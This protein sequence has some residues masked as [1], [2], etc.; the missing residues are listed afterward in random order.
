MENKQ[1]KIRT[2]FAPSPT[3]E[4]HLGGARTALFAYLFARQNKGK[5][6]LRIEDTDLDRLVKGA[7]KRIIESLNW[8]GIKFDSQPIYQSKRLKIYQKFAKKLVAENKAYWCH[9]SPEKLAQMRQEQ[10]Q[11]KIAPKYDGCCRDKN[12]KEQ[13]GAVVRLKMPAVGEITVNDLIRGEVI[14]KNELLDDPVLLKS[15]NYPT[16]HLANVID[17]YQTKI[18]HVIRSEEWLSSTPKH[19]VLYQA[20]GWPAPQFAHLPMILGSD[21]AKLSKR[22]GA[23]AVLD[24][25]KQGYLPE[26]LINFIA[27]L[28][29]NPGTEKEIFSLEELIK[30]FSLERVNESAA[31]FNLEKLNW[32]NGYYL[33][34]MQIDELTKKCLPYLED[35]G[36]LKKFPISNFQFLNNF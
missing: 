18:S 2:R 27:F 25:K 24:Y 7:D 10:I 34:Q 22:H 31:I 29:W 20:F 3:G 19:L 8:L 21:K 14:F 15:D 28:G 26:A 13:K 9:C 32:L 36:V 11:N 17:D 6:F 33:R 23:T 4:L 30:E 1:L 12:L 5:F 16:Y 35:R